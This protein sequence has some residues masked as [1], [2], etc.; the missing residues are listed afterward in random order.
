MNDSDHSSAAASRPHR[1]KGEQSDNVSGARTEPEG[2]SSLWAR[3][4]SLFLRNAPT[5]REDLYLA[6][7]QSDAGK[8]AF[9]AGERTMLTN[10][11]KLGKMRVQDVA[12]PRADIEAI[13]KDA[14]LGQVVE[15][16]RS[17]AH[18]RLPV[19][20][21]N[22]DDIIGMIH[23]KDALQHLSAPVEKPNGSPI[24]MLNAALKHKLGNCKNLIRK[25]L[26]VPPSMPVSDLLQSMQATRLHM[27]IVVDEYG[28]TDGLVTIEDLL[29]AVVGDIEDEHDDEDVALVLKEGE[30][31]YCAEARASLEEL[32]EI[33]GPDF[34]P[35][36][37]AEEADTLGGLVFSLIDRVPVRGEVITRLKGFEFEILAADPRRV[38]R[39][40]ILKRPR[41][42]LVR[43]RQRPELKTPAN[44]KPDK[45]SE[46]NLINEKR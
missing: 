44:P 18:S 27:S 24:K 28:G 6:L 36:K 25:V 35:G 31:V 13:D 30:N 1:L 34:D 4:K 23:I 14:S 11:L 2:K 29:E 40:R 7:Q 22:L 15:K 32:R 38:R 9:T 37:L 19:F 21:E 12:V 10:V 33:I 45:Q 5:L 3:I 43:P 8:S 42:L 39:V 41:N 20:A 17:S 26:F 16:F 46:K